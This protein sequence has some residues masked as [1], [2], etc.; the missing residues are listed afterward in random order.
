M[1]K[2]LFAKVFVKNTIWWN[3]YFFVFIEDHFTYSLIYYNFI[4]QF[5]TLMN[6]WFYLNRSKPLSSKS[7]CYICREKWAILAF[8]EI[9]RREDFSS[10][11]VT[12][13]TNFTFQNS[14]HCDWRQECE[15]TT[16]MERFT[17]F[18]VFDWFL[19]D[20]D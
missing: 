13:H 11:R 9:N 2:T 6:N 15:L 4:L 16:F 10:D 1:K 18:F 3:T 14:K 7:F 8:F 20:L 17:A 5:L 12:L 19:E